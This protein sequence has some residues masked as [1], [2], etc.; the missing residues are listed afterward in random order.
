MTLSL[1]K[2]D[3]HDGALKSGAVSQY[4]LVALLCLGALLSVFLALAA[5]VSPS[6]QS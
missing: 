3:I 5:A 4:L 6:K 1:L 2:E